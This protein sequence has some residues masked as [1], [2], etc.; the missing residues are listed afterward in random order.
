VSPRRGLLLHRDQRLGA[1]PRAMCCRASGTFGQEKRLPDEE[2]SNRYLH[3]LCGI[4][5]L[6]HYA[7]QR[8]APEGRKHIAQGVSPVKKR[9][10]TNKP[11]R[12]DTESNH[13]N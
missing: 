10:E 11:R 12:G 2:R 4:R 3:S 6:C 7:C 1:E 5:N 8:R 9:I 13:S